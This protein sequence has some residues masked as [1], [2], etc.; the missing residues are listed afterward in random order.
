MPSIHSTPGP[1]L[2]IIDPLEDHRGILAHEL[3]RG[4]FRVLEARGQDHARKLLRALK[5][6]LILADVEIGQGESGFAFCKKIKKNPST[7]RIPII[8][9]SKEKEDQSWHKLGVSCGA[10]A[11]IDKAEK[12]GAVIEKVRL[13][14]GK[15]PAAQDYLNCSA[16]SRLNVLAADDDPAILELLE[17]VLSPERGFR[18]KCVVSGKAV[19]KELKYRK[20]D[21]ILADWNMPGIEGLDVLRVIR[22][23]PTLASTVVFLV[24]GRDQVDDEIEALEAGV[25]GYIYKPFRPEI[26]VLKIRNAVRLATVSGSRSEIVSLPDLE[27]NPKMRKARLRG[28]PLRLGKREFQVLYALASRP[29]EVVKTED[30]LKPVSRRNGTSAKHALEQVVHRLREKLGSDTSI[31]L[32]AWRGEGYLLAL[33]RS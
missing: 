14:L 26:M 30:L 28:V 9:T 3:T 32:E 20:Y 25:D 21:A 15:G 7:S 17:T 2:L 19:L 12:P 27:L 29:N 5:P 31:R 16:V 10:V 24:T 4:G 22:A 23:E 18:L 33:P 13:A 6:D 8:M 1:T 11:C